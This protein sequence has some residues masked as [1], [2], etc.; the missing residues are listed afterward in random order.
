MSRGN[1]YGNH[2]STRERIMAT[3]DALDPNLRFLSCNTVANWAPA[4]F[5]HEYARARL[6]GQS[7][8]SAVQY[9]ARRITAYEADDTLRDY[10]P[11]HPEA[12]PSRQAK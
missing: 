3:H 5:D 4:Q 12:L 2:E 6:M 8:R 9:V 7:H 11:T 1:G 10:G